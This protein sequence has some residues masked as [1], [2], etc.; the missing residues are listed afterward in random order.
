MENA[1]FALGFAKAK[2]SLPGQLG[3]PI[4]L[5]PVH[6]MVGN[7]TN[8]KGVAKL[9]LP[10]PNADFK[11]LEGEIMGIDIPSEVVR[12]C[13]GCEIACSAFHAEPK[14]SSINPARS[15]IRV[16]THRLQDIWLPVFAGGRRRFLRI[17]L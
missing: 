4:L 8:S 15:R 1:L 16:L 13:R 17:G 2:G 12:Y 10:L 3:C 5:Q 7:P 9:R 6:I 14:Y 11:I